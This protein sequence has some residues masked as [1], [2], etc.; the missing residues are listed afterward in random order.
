VI[1]NIHYANINDLAWNK[2]GKLVAC[3]SDGYVSMYNSW[4]IKELERVPYDELP[5][6]L[7]EYFIALD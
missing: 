4:E 2:E 1:G 6:E 7:R 3:S 5:E